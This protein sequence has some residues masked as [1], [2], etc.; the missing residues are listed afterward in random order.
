MRVYWSKLDVSAY[1]FKNK[2]HYWILLDNEISSAILLWDLIFYQGNVC[3]KLTT[4]TVTYSITTVFQR[5]LHR[6][7]FPHK[8]HACIKMCPNLPHYF[9]DLLFDSNSARNASCILLSRPETI[10]RARN[11]EKLHVYV[12]LKQFKHKTALY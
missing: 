1:W 10:V 4:W 9:C 11:K 8:L 3:W 7:R 12:S 2:W 6:F 5:V